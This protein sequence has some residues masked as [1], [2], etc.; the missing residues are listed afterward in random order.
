MLIREEHC[1]LAV[2]DATSY[3]RLEEVQ[4]LLFITSLKTALSPPALLWF[5]QQ[6]VIHGIWVYPQPRSSPSSQV[7]TGEHSTSLEQ[8]SLHIP[9]KEPGGLSPGFCWEDPTTRQQPAA[10]ALPTSAPQGKRGDAQ[11]VLTGF[12]H[13]CKLPCYQPRQGCDC[14]KCSYVQER[15]CGL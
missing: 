10:P 14:C 12:L 1:V 4:M 6:G 13:S 5:Q 7:L 15:G 11:L 2:E 3:C 8:L 9:M